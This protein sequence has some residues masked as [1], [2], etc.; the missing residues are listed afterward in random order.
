MVDT[1]TC[2][3]TTTCQGV[4]RKEQGTRESSQ[5]ASKVTRQ[6][7]EGCVICYGAGGALFVYSFVGARQSDVA[8]VVMEM[9]APLSG[10]DWRRLEELGVT[11][12]YPLR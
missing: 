6:V 8:G 10:G 3:D 1:K 2:Q 11:C 5:Q 4:C 9:V 7:L 12:V